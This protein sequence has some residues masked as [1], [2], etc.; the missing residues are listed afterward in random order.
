MLFSLLT[1]VQERQADPTP[2][3]NIDFCTLHFG[4]FYPSYPMH[5]NGTQFDDVIEFV[6]S[7]YL[8]GKRRA[9]KEI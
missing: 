8:L 2:H 5:A 6:F 1:I 9:N 7:F 3:K 4:S